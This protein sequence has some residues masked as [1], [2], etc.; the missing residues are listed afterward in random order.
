MSPAH[1]LTRSNLN[2]LEDNLLHQLARHIKQVAPIPDN[3][4]SYAGAIAL[5]SGIAGR[6][7][8]TPTR[9][10]L[11]QYVII[12][13][14]TGIGKEGAMTGIGSIFSSLG[15]EGEDLQQ[16]FIGPGYIASGQAL[17]G[18]LA[19][20]PNILCSIG[21]IGHLFR[22]LSTPQCGPA[23]SLLLR[24]L[25]ALHNKSG[26]TDSL[27]SS[28]WAD[29]NRNLPNIKSPAISILG[30]STPR[31]FYKGMNADMIQQG[32]Y[33]RLM[34]F[35]V[36]KELPEK[37]PSNYGSTLELPENV[38]HRLKLLMTYC[39]QD[40]YSICD[41]QEGAHELL[42]Q[43]FRDCNK[44]RAKLANT[45]AEDILTRS[46]IKALRLASLFAVCQGKNFTEP[47]PLITT[48]HALQA[49]K[50]EK[51]ATSGVLD[52]VAGGAIGTETTERQKL[53]TLLS[54]FSHYVDIKNDPRAFENDWGAHGL[55]DI[56]LVRKRGI[57]PVALVYPTL[58]EHNIFDGVKSRR[59]A[60]C[61]LL[62]ELVQHERLTF[63]ERGDELLQ[64]EKG[65][66]LTSGECYQIR[67]LKPI[68][69]THIDWNLD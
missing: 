55:A 59:K 38:S 24:M 17:I 68:G 49:I 66:E 62:L 34:V 5:L 18:E 42:D 19:E 57:I 11:N 29:K 56:H 23:D 27:Q 67:D 16:R 37:P 54:W 28:S 46:H 47:R 39:Q 10:G 45:P 22:Q 12:L 35:E 25:L 41:W 44:Q 21:E 15:D 9:T 13:G 30:D 32:L 33:P 61:E 69:S 7:Y 60:L 64:D 58:S 6:R 8:N 50:I 31:Y 4:I 48:N 3:T 52:R 20:N 2:F 65:N 51:F 40:E 1:K 14:R 63:I 36:E 53:N 43:Y 26:I